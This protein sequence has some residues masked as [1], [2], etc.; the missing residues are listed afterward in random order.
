MIEYYSQFQIVG[1][2]AEMLYMKPPVHKLLVDIS[3]DPPGHEETA[4]KKHPTRISFTIANQDLMDRFLAEASIGDV[5]EA[6]GT[7]Q[8]SGYIPHKTT[9]IDTTF[10]M[11]DFRILERQPSP[12]KGR[13]LTTSTENGYPLN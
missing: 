1:E 5:T 4:F 2:I 6:T 9:Y 10:L 3:L 12:V 13:K 11:K 8:Q 7:F